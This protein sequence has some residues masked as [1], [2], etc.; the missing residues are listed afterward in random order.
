MLKNKKIMILSILTLVVFMSATINIAPVNA[1]KSKVIG[2]GQKVIWSEKYDCYGK[3]SWKAY[4]K[5]NKFVKVFMYVNYP[6][7]KRKVRSIF[8]IKN[9]N[10]NRIQVNI[11]ANNNG[12]ISRDSNKF[13]LKGYSALKFYYKIFQPQIFSL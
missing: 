2:H 10:K 5:G 12:K 9:I 8:T 7:V 1:A 13:R 4:K 3:L 6:N 11:V